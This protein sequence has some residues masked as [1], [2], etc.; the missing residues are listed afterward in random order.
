MTAPPPH[1][2]PAGPDRELASGLDWDRFAPRLQAARTRVLFLDYD[3]TLAPFREDWR[4]AQPY[5]GVRAAL[6]RILRAG[7][8]RVVIATGRTV[9]SV[10]PLLGLAI[11]PEIWGVHGWERQHPD[12]RREDFDPGPLVREGIRRALEP[13]REPWGAQ[14]PGQWE[15]KPTSVA[16]HFRGLPEAEHGEFSA[17]VEPLWRTIAAQ[18]GMH[19]HAFD[20]GMELRIPGRTKGT[21]VETV[22]AEA[23]SAESESRAAGAG[24]QAPG[25]AAVFLGDDTTDEDAFR[26]LAARRD[27]GTLGVLVRQAWRPTAAQ[28]WLRPPQDLLDLLE[29][30]HRIAGG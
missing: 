7:Q 2:A 22:L 20:F 12:G 25:T 30:W 21:V 24:A 9:D 14:W 4:H 17:R 6:E 3:G 27:P 5:P 15:A 28:A 8:T 16:F 1:A 26:A 18:H 23:G 13:S 29:R 19:L 10:R 11:A